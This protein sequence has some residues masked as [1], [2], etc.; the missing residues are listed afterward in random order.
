M[1]TLL[2]KFGRNDLRVISRDLFTFWAVLMTLIVWLPIRIAVPLLADWLQRTHGFDL[3]PYYPLIV[4]MIPMA[5]IA[6]L[7][8]LMFGLLV[9]DER[10]NNTLVALQVT[11]LSIRSYAFYRVLLPACYGTVMTLLNLPLLGLIP[12]TLWLPAAVTAIG[13]IFTGPIL[14]MLL[15]AYARSKIEAITL[16]RGVTLLIPA[17]LVAYFVDSDWQYLFGINPVYWP[18]KALWVYWEG[19]NGLP[20]VL[21][22]LVYGFFISRFLFARFRRC[23]GEIAVSRIDA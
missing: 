7:L 13:F 9:L 17:T 2:K 15:G 4:G 16:F 14:A 11:P 1:M 20:Y 5:T 22:G 12:S 18:M 19:G 8:G 6:L 3:V 23:L 21:I 10:D